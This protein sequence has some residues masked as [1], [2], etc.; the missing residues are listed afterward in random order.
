M[1]DPPFTLTRVYGLLNESDGETNLS[2]GNVVK[3]ARILHMAR[4]LVVEPEQGDAL[5]R[6]RR[7]SLASHIGDQEALVLAYETVV[8]C[9]LLR[10]TGEAPV[11]LPQVSS[12][13]GLDNSEDCLA[14]CSRVLEDAKPIVAEMARLVSDRV[15][16]GGNESTPL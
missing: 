2:L 4:A 8:V 7:M 15:L 1:K 5:F 13:L 11:D 12:T 9:R 16:H 10:V 6:D 3:Y 14:Y